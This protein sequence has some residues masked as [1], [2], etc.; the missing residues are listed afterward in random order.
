MLGALLLAGCAETGH[1]DL[2]NDT[3][4]DVS[5]RFTDEEAMADLG[6]DGV[7]D[8]PAT[9][10][11]SIPSSTCYDGPFLVTYPDGRIIEVRGDLCPGQELWVRD[12]AAELRE[13][14]SSG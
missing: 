13:T 11:A 3:E 12:G 10:G 9:G 14:S 2:R 1:V 8:V 4:D 7:V 6:A 5:V